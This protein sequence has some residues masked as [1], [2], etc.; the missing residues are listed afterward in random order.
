V[1]AAL[2]ETPRPFRKTPEALHEADAFA[3]AGLH[4][5]YG[6]DAGVEFVEAFP[7]EDVS[8]VLF[9]LDLFAQPVEDLTEAL[10]AHTHVV[11]EEGGCTYLLPELAVSLWRRAPTDARLASVDAA[12]PGYQRLAVI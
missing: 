2:R 9:G 8:V 10:A 3:R 1:L 12:E 11:A 4:V 5:H 7:A 6:D